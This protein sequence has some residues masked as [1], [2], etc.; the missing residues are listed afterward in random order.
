MDVSVSVVIPTYN[1]EDTLCVTLDAL[2]NQTLP[3][4]E[5]IVVETGVISRSKRFC[6]ILI[7][8]FTSF[9]TNRMP[10]YKMPEILATNW[11]PASM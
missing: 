7:Q 4:F 9:G 8:R 10:V 1:N 6:K 3:A 11:L 2:I 5:I